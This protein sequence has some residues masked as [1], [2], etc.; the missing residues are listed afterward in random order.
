MRIAVRTMGDPKLMDNSIRRAVWSLDPQLAVS[1]MQT[2]EQAISESEAPRRFNT[3]VLSAF[4]FGAVLLAALGIYGVI[5]YSAAERTHEIAIR[6]ALGAQTAGMFRLILGS[7][8]RL[9]MVGCALGLAGGAAATRIVQP[10]LFE[11]SPFDP[12]VFACAAA[13]VFILALAASF[14]PARRATK[15]DPMV[16]LRCE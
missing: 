5:A 11:V 16:A 3:V 6:M 10:L 12:A 1:N 14:L 15:V 13:G 2:L 4:A 9:A 8:A 7:G